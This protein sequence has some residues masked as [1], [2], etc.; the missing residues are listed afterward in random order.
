MS[1]SLPQRRGFA[2]LFSL[3][4][5]CVLGLAGLVVGSYLWGHFGPPAADADDTGGYLFSLLVGGILGAFGIAVPLW[6]FW[7]RSAKTS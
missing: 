7:P 1:K 6:M 2:I 5:A 4:M 3:S